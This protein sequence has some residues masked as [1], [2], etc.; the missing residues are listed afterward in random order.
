M[1]GIIFQTHILTHNRKWL[2]GTGGADRNGDLLIMEQK[3]PKSLEPQ[4]DEGL[5]N[6]CNQQ[7]IAREQAEKIK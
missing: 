6:I 2:G 5:F 7:V 4:G 3:R 1:Q